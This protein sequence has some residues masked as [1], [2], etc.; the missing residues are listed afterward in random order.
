MFNRAGGHE[1]DAS[2]MDGR[3]LGGGG[4]AAVHTVRHPISLAGL[5]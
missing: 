2:I 1:L 5:S 3:T 4:V